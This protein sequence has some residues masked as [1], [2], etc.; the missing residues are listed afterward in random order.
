MLWV[1]RKEEIETTE[2][3]SRSSILQVQYNRQKTNDCAVFNKL[4][5]KKAVYSKTTA[6]SLLTK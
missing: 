1:H 6:G 2:F 5:K 3:K 4:Q